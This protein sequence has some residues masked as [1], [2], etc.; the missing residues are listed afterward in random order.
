LYFL[1][2]LFRLLLLLISPSERRR[3]AH[4]RTGPCG[5]HKKPAADI[6]AAAG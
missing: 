5:A 3:A 1:L 6:A 2:L 4:G